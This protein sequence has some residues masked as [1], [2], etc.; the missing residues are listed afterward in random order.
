MVTTGT[1]IAIAT[2]ITAVGALAVA[3]R[4]WIPP[5]PPPVPDYRNAEDLS[6]TCY[7][8]ND[9]ITCSLTNRSRNAAFTCMRANLK[10]K[11]TGASAEP[12][13]FC[14]GPIQPYETKT[15]TAQ[16]SSFVAKL[17]PNENL[18]NVPDWEA[19]AFDTESFDPR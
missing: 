18:K 12:V 3:V 11:K 5:S 17:C 1:V 2:S 9:T 14:S 13:S 10:N 16:W 4:V 8:S 15:L 19:C 6:R 7:A